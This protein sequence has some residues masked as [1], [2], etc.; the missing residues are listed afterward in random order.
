ME[1]SKEPWKSE[2]YE[3]EKALKEKLT[4][5][6]AERDAYRADAVRCAAA[7]LSA[8]AR[9]QVLRDALKLYSGGALFTSNTAKQALAAYKELMG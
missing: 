7:H 1:H 2:C 6:E 3:T 4:Q 9:E 5:V 8:I